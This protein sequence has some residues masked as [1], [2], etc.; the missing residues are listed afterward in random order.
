MEQNSRNSKNEFDTLWI[1]LNENK[2]AEVINEA[3]KFIQSDK[4]SIKNYVHSF[5]TKLINLIIEV[6]HLLVI[7]LIKKTIV[8]IIYIIV[9]KIIKIKVK[10]FQQLLLVVY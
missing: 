8:N 7:L 2:Y 9:L 5:L 3:T 4:K 10:I 6:I 1:K